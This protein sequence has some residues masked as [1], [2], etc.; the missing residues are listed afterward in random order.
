MVDRVVCATVDE[1][2]SALDLEDGE[3]APGRQHHLGLGLDVRG[4]PVGYGRHGRSDVVAYET[5]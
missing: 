2:H 3:F 4:R 1:L 5:A